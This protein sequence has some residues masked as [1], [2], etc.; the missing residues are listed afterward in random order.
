MGGPICSDI[1]A[2]KAVLLKEEASLW[3]VEDVARGIRRPYMA[4]GGAPSLRPNP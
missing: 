2:M 3:C 1:G 4:R